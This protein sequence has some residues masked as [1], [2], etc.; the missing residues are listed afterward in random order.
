MTTQQEPVY[1]LGRSDRETQRL[2]RQAQLYNPLTRRLLIAAGVGQGMRVLDIGSGAG[3]VALLLADLV[4]PSGHVVGID[5]DGT[6]LEVARRRIQA[7]GWANVDFV[8]GDARTVSVE[9]QFDAVVG[10][11]VLGYVSDPVQLLR[12]CVHRLRPAGLIV[13][14]A[15]DATSFFDTAP[16]CSIVDAW[17]GWAQRGLRATGHSAP[18]Y[19]YRELFCEAGLTEP[20]M[21]YEAPIGG[22]VDWIGYETMADLARGIRPALLQHGIATDAEMDVETLADRLRAHVVENHGVFRCM[23]AVGI[24]AR[25][26]VAIA[27]ASSN[28]S[29]TTS[30]GDR[31]APACQ[32]ASND[33]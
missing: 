6:I 33:R 26:A 22:G 30:A 23:P 8:E 11:F 5:I 3:D 27:F 29:K 13:F 2:Q 18:A 1:V 28:D 7:V 31:A 19:R 25:A 16:P 17:R 15:Q 14:Q 12:V 4:G 10:R 9:G 24:W 21:C 32:A 20:R